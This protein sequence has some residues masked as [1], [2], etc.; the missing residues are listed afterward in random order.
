M[1]SRVCSAALCGIEAKPVS[2]EVDVSDGLPVINMVGDL[3]ANVREAR[4]RVRTAIHNEGIR[5]PVKRIT[6]NL[7]P[8]DFHKEGTGFDLPIAI[9]MMASMGMV[10]P[11][12]L[13]KVMFAGELGLNG[14]LAPVRGILQ[15]TECARLGGC[16]TCIVPMKNLAEGSAVCGIRVL[17]A[18]SLHDVLLYLAGR[19]ELAQKAINIEEMR[20]HQL[21]GCQSDFKDLKGQRTV[22]RAAEV[23]VAGLHNLLLIG[24]P[25]S[26]KTMTAQRI[27]SILPE[28][29]P[30]EILEVSRIHSAAG[31]LPP[32]E[33]LMTVRPFRSPHH[34]ATS[35]A[36]SGG[37]K[38]PRP[39]EVSLAH[40]GV[41]YLDELP[42]FNPQVLEIL[43]GPMEDGRIS[44]SRNSGTMTFPADFML[45]AS[46]NP[47]KCGYFPDRRK[48]RCTPVQVR[49]Y[50]S[51][52]SQPLLDRIDIC[53][54]AEEVKYSDI[55]GGTEGE[56]SADIRK[57][58]EKVREIQAQ[59]YEDEPWNY[60]SALTGSGLEK[61]CP[62]GKEE[63]DYMRGIF[64]LKGLTG[65]SYTRIIKVA[66][67]IADLAG[68]EDIRL[69][70]LSEAVLYRS[71]EKE[72]WLGG[73]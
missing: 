43:R 9:G 71:L 56:C 50:L 20:K 32:E 72:Y 40:L 7:S 26:G 22:R 24:P 64:E 62:L 51:R 42:E 39:G 46:M 70:H 27:P 13:E 69:E 61:Y 48:C 3:S 12:R 38:I 11:G 21:I 45:V 23:A 8:A 58:V 15:M 2:V 25:G 54:R 17:G 34:T 19:K 1:F 57:R 18:E 65:R 29:T 31:M 68:S 6:I 55:A 52:I 53:V 47:C 33:G 41:L 73:G 63:R 16:Q 4:D 44:I 36:L 59:R 37:G 28:M 30:E 14:Q 66:R 67:T 35:A 10:N 5:F 60:N 49:N